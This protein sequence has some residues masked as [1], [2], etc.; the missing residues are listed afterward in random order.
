MSDEEI[1]A[2][3]REP[4][5]AREAERK[6]EQEAKAKADLA[7][8]REHEEFANKPAAVVATL[9]AVR[10]RAK[11][12]GAVLDG[13]AV[14]ALAACKKGRPRGPRKPALTVGVETVRFL[15][16]DKVHPKDKED[17]LSRH[18]DRAASVSASLSPWVEYERQARYQAVLEKPERSPKDLHQDR[19]RLAGKPSPLLDGHV[20]AVFAWE[21]DLDQLDARVVIIDGSNR[22]LC[23][24]ELEV[25]S[26]VQI[27]SLGGA[28]EDA[29]REERAKELR[30][31]MQ[32]ALAETD[33]PI[34]PDGDEVKDPTANL[35]RIPAPE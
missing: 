13:P 3:M 9:A 28:T 18:W 26:R 27:I 16:S 15:A 29:Q 4:E 35:A 17:G 33:L 20:I 5:E 34:K 11:A 10:E 8:A 21:R 31:R 22:L 30:W 32:L 19:E 24:I 2:K 7:L 12:I 23:R 14:D 1:A 6:A 25:K